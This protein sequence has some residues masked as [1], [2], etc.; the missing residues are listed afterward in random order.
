MTWYQ[1]R[2]V[3]QFGIAFQKALCQ[4][5]NWSHNAYQHSGAKG[6]GQ[7]EVRYKPG[8]QRPHGC[9]GTNET[10]NGAFP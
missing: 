10:A 3:F 5:A 1:L 2:G 6:V 9:N 8:T 4:I 7:G